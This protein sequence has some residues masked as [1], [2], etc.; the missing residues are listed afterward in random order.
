MP[1]VFDGLDLGEEPVAADVEAPTVARHGPADAPHHVVGLEHDRVPA[2]LGE[3]I[4]GG[5][6]RRPG[7][8]HH[9]GT[10]VP[11]CRRRLRHL[12]SY[13][14]FGFRPRVKATGWE[15]PDPSPPGQPR[16]TRTTR[17]RHIEVGEGQQGVDG[18][19][20]RGQGEDHPLHAA[21]PTSGRAPASTNGKAD[22]A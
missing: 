5:E 9:H 11:P 14:P 19:A 13:P 4:G 16:I 1:Q 18:Q 8:D 22:N 20:R 21:A 17:S 15:H 10:I 3:L 6:P 7:P 2:R 12:A